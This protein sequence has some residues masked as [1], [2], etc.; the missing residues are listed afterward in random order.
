MGEGI[1]LTR[2]A[3]RA[4]LPI[5]YND[6]GNPERL[7]NIPYPRMGFFQNGPFLQPCR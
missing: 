5:I 4:Q 2:D 6:E 1:V 3:K 7:K